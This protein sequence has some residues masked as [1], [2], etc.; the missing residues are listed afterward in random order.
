MGKVEGGGRD[1]KARL[2]MV[3]MSEQLF[4]KFTTSLVLWLLRL[5]ACS[6]KYCCFLGQVT[7]KTIRMFNLVLSEMDIRP[8]GLLDG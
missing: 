6:S 4:D 8:G 3:P 5:V 7:C 2:N 1:S